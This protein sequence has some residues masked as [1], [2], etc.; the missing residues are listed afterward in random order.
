MRQGEASPGR[1][2]VE[3]RTFDALWW[4]AGGSTAASRIVCA[5]GLRASLIGP[6]L[7]LFARETKAGWDC[8]G[9]QAGLFDEGAVPTRRQPSRLVDHVSE[10]SV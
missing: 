4:R 5:S 2:P 8:W 1:D 10:I 7:S 6:T 9:N 3:P